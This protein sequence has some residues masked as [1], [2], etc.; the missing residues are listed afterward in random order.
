MQIIDNKFCGKFNPANRERELAVAVIGDV[1]RGGW[2]NFM[3][4][5]REDDQIDKVSQVSRWALLY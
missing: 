2:V 1:V 5:I 3:E 4:A